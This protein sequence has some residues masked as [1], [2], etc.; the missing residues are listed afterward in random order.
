M[1]KNPPFFRKTEGRNSVFL[2]WLTAGGAEADE[3]EGIS[4]NETIASVN[5]RGNRASHHGFYGPLTGEGSHH[6]AD[7]P[8]LKQKQ[9]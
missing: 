7:P 5:L 2:P 6:I 9:R 3:R 1:R 8:N 4:E